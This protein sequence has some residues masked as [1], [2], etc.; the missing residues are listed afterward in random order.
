MPDPAQIPPTSTLEVTESEVL[1][2]IAR[3][4]VKCKLQRSA[5][6][7]NFHH[8]AANFPERALDNLLYRLEFPARGN[9]RL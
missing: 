6:I 7:A 4:V 1:G 9:A 8:V 5:S 3:R 2:N